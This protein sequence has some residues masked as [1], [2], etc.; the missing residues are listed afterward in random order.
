MNMSF[1]SVV[2]LGA[3]LGLVGCSSA[4]KAPKCKGD[5]VRVNT[6]DCY[7]VVDDGQADASARRTSCPVRNSPQ[8]TL[9]EFK[10]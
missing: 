5:F 9:L 1:V 7:V 6:S 8:S 4:P 2:L 3:A 10:P